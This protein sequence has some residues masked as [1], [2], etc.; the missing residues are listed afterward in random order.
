MY[1]ETPG[2]RRRRHVN[3]SRRQMWESAN[4]DRIEERAERVRLGVPLT[5]GVPWVRVREV[6]KDLALEAAKPTADPEVVRGAMKAIETMLGNAPAPLDSFDD[7]PEWDGLELEVAIVSRQAYTDAM[8][9]L[10][11]H[12]TE[13][14]AVPKD[15]PDDER[16]RALVEGS[17]KINGTML[18]FVALAVK[19]VHGLA[20]LDGQAVRMPEGDQLT[21]EEL[22]TLRSAGLMEPLFAIARATQE[23]DPLELGRFGQP[24]ESTSTHRNGTAESAPSSSSVAADAER[25]RGS[26]GSP[27]PLTDPSTSARSGDS[28]ASPGSG[29]R[30]SAT[31]RAT[32]GRSTSEGAAPS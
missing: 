9:E 6:A 32:A 13:T 28:G 20:D 3:T 11:A 8:L 23:L 14:L 12:Q 18:A 16:T 5:E 26:H 2:R 15:L 29:G 24:Q 31:G 4:K 19:R 30:N 1:I 10:G 7:H 17:E 21:E 22:K 25:T 27:S